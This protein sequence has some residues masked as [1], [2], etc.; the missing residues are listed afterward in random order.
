MQHFIAY[1][2][3][4]SGNIVIAPTV[5]VYLTGTEDEATIFSD[6]ASTSKANPFTGGAD[7]LVDFY[8]DVGRYDVLIESAS[9]ESVTLTDV[10]LIEPAEGSPGDPSAATHAAAS[11]TTPVDADEIPLVDSAA[12]FGL[13]KLTWA[14]LKAT[15]KTYFD[16]LYLVAT[17]AL[18]ALGALTPAA[19]RVPYF[20]SGSA[21][22]LLTLD[23]DGTLA[24]N[25]DT[26]L[27][28]Q[29]AVKT[30]ADTKQTLD[31]DLTAIAGLS[32]S[33]D[34]FIQRKSSAWTNRTIAQVRADLRTVNVQS[35]T[36]SAT[37][38]PTFDD[39]LV[40]IT[41]QAAALS[42]A[43]PTGTAIPGLGIVIR[44]KD[45]GTARAISY[46]TQYRAIG[47]T[48]P[49]TTVLSKTLYLAM[50]YNSD[51]TRWDVL[52]VGQEA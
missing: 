33:N 16:T 4:A 50:I 27:A 20:T 46:D 15:L 13:K 38:T 49:T 36:S 42:L 51:D 25:S 10:T 24:A 9:G 35:V 23:I 26:T 32:A 21:A 22:S 7:G 1:A 45:N 3:D 31:S 30:Y 48:L 52:A 47:V 19:S 43:N 18:T 39:D 34:D 14:N 2:R 5:T 37:V 29:K 41:A 28:T 6:N 8:A 12:S 44:I 11:K 17:T 40:K